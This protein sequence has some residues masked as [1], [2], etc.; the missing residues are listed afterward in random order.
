MPRFLIEI[1][2][3]LTQRE[4]LS[5]EA[6]TDTIEAVV[7]DLDALS[8]DPSIGA[9]RSGDSV[10]LTVEV[11]VQAEDDAL[12]VGV[13]VDHVRNVLRRQPGLTTALSSVR[14]RS[15]GLAPT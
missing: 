13:A 3:R 4:A 1:G 10:D 11:V 14:V 7:D 9:T 5:D 6:I 8:V 2:G 12:A 15:S